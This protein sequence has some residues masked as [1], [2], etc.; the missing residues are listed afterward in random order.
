MGFLNNSIT[1]MFL[2]VL[3]LLSFLTFTVSYDCYSH[4]PCAAGKIEVHD[5]PECLNLEQTLCPPAFRLKNSCGGLVEIDTGVDALSIGDAQRITI[6]DAKLNK[7][8]SE[9]SYAL[10]FDRLV[11]KCCVLD[12]LADEWTVMANPEPVAW[13]W[14]VI[15]R[16]YKIE[17]A[18]T[19]S[20]GEPN[21]TA[22]STTSIPFPITPSYT[23]TTLSESTTTTTQQLPEQIEWATTTT[24]PTYTIE[25]VTM[26]ISGVRHPGK[27]ARSCFYLN[28]IVYLDAA[29]IIMLLIVA[30]LYVSVSRGLGH[31]K[32]NDIEF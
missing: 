4:Y 6:N 8:I 11:K 12:D 25:N 1:V 23:T 9:P 3:M 24:L 17:K 2:L 20:A 26:Y 18:V 7:W 28:M 19:L 15:A 5:V 13:E 27:T 32:H 21:E 30:V 14:K 10:D 31:E 29:V 16:G 22:E